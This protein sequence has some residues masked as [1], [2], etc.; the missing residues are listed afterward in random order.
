MKLGKRQ[1][2]REKKKEEE[3]HLKKHIKAVSEIKMFSDYH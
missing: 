2:K 1:E 3:Q